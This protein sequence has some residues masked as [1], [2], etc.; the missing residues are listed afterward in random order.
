MRG[1]LYVGVAIHTG[2]HAAVDG[3]F[4]R[5][6]INVQANNF[7]VHFVRQRSIA[8]AGQTFLNRGLGE[9]FLGRSVERAR[10]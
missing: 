5:L 3:I 7:A 1:A 6:R 9:I 2:E 4:K 8:V 10:C